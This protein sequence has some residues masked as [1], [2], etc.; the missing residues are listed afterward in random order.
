MYGAHAYGSRSY[1]SSDISLDT[2]VTVIYSEL[3]A[4]IVEYDAPAPE[5]VGGELAIFTTL[6]E[7]VLSSNT[8]IDEGSGNLYDIWDI[9]P[10]VTMN[11][12]VPVVF[13]VVRNLA[14]T[15]E[16]ENNIT[17]DSESVEVTRAEAWWNKNWLYRRYLSITTPPTGI[18]VS[19][20]MSVYLSKDVFALNKVRDDWKD[21]RVVELV[22]LT[23]ET[24]RVHAHDIE[25]TSSHLIIRFALPTAM[26][27]NT[28]EEGKY[29]VYYGNKYLTGAVPVDTYAWSLYPLEVP[30]NAPG[31]TYTKAGVHWI[32]GVSSKR[33]SRGSFR[34]WGSR[35]RLYSN[36]GPDQGVLQVRV[37]DDEWT[38]VDLFNYE[39]SLDEMVFEATDLADDKHVLKFRV[40][41]A[42]H[43]S[44][45]AITCNVSKITYSKFGIFTNVKEQANSRL[46]W[47]SGVG[48]KS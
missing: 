38:N 25:E 35:V 31:I 5:T 40:S 6:A 34:F 23:P 48:G 45:S 24:W 39:Q 8:A 9:T 44:S 1:G 47:G 33:L 13:T 4:S 28:S 22:S 41:G 19:H 11:H 18:Q 16:H 42:K 43:P 15:I 3:E 36:K 30:Y 26:A 20:P 12:L 46:F 32:D 14:P 17:T 37:D 2:E 7:V 27:R 10:T 29:F 21:I